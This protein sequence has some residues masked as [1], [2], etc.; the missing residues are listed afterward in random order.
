MKLI[1]I[2]E[3]HYVVVD[4]TEIKEGDC[5]FNDY[6][7]TIVKFSAGRG[8]GLCKKITHSTQPIDKNGYWG[9]VMPLTLTIFEIKELIGEMDVEWKYTEEDMRKAWNA[10]YIDAMSIDEETY[11]P[12]FFEDFIQS[13]Q[14]KT[15]WEVDIINGKFTLI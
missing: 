13:L 7:K 11:K 10:A 9:K 6:N 8:I 14:P 1:K 5:V 12:L 4:E 15:E 2:N 3:D